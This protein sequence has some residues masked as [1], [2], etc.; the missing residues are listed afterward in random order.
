MDEVNALLETA[1]A[2]TPS[3]DAVIA[4]V[5]RGGHIL[6]VRAEAG[7]PLADL[8]YLVFAIDG[9]VAKA[10]TAA[11][12]ANDQ[13]PLTSRT[14]QFISQTTI[15]ERMVRSNPNADPVAAPLVRGPGFVAPIG[16]AG[17]FPPGIQFTP[18]VDLFAIEHTNRDSI[19]HPGRDHIRGTADDIVMPSR[20][21]ADPAFIP[22]GQEIDPPESYGRASGLRPAAQ[23]RGIGTLPGGVPIYKDSNL[24]GDVRPGDSLVGGI[25]VFFPGPDGFA[26]FEQGADAAGRCSVPPGKRGVNAPCVLE[27]EFIAAAAA[28]TADAVLRVARLR[29]RLDLV[30]I[31]LD[32]VGPRGTHGLR[33]LLRFGKRLGAGAVNGVNQPLIGGGADMTLDGE[34]VPEGTITTLADGSIV[35]SDYLVTPHDSPLGTITAADVTTIITQG[36]AEALR[37]R[38]AIRLPLSRST[39]MVLSVAD[40]DGNVLGTFRMPDATFFSIDVAVA[41]ARNVAYYAN[42][43]PGVLQAIDR[44]DTNG[45]GVGDLEPGVAFTNR[46]FRFVALPHV[47]EGID[48]APPG[49]FSIIND[50]CVDPRTA[51][52]T[53]PLAF[54]AFASVQGYDAINVG[55]NFR[56]DQ[57]LAAGDPRIANQNGIVFFPGSSPIYRDAD[58]DGVPELVGGLGVSGDGVDQDDVVT[59]GGA[60]G[61]AP[62]ASV[63]RADDVHVRGVRLPYLKFLRNPEK[64]K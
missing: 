2:A 13:A 40:N 38:A 25:G 24:D 20:F 44:L 56:Y 41:K 51:A 3:T 45:D 35:L 47:P 60:A 11:F 16:I 32:T 59:F 61:F 58:G 8:D 21:N 49:P 48:A 12:F 7:V 34:P 23:S 14:V 26:T 28:T 42:P 63:R 43:A 4:V 36:V 62:P 29:G 33:T 52:E 22:P 31:T 15:T 1:S 5:D 55:S 37:V 54:T 39:R 50:G 19:V 17:H 6:G 30:G 64:R 10:R 27:A 46:T 53:C 9:A 57:G 18:Q